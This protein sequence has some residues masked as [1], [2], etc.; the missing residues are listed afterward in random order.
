MSCKLLDSATFQTVVESTPLV[1][2]DLCIVRDRH[3]LLGLRN[4][5]P[6]AG[7]WFTPG[8][9]LLKNEPWQQGLKRIAQVELGLSLS[10]KQCQL[11]GVW[12]HFYDN[13]AVSEK[14]STHYV[15]LPHVLY[16]DDDLDL[17]VDDQHTAIR[18]FDLEEVS[19]SEE[20]HKYMNIYAG[21]ILED[22]RS[23]EVN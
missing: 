1:S 19:H 15:N 17:V 2:I 18:W 3:I 22:L 21:W 4:N 12:D 11:M 14:I 20:H 8:G 10:A 9:R 6:L 23:K 13:S 5:E 7:R 16:V